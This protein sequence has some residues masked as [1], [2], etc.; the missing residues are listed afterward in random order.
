MVLSNS[1]SSSSSSTSHSNSSSRPG[2]PASKVIAVKESSKKEPKPS[3]YKPVS[4]PAPSASSK[5]PK[6]PTLKPKVVK[7]KTDVVKSEGMEK[8][9]DADTEQLFVE[10]GSGGGNDEAQVYERTDGLWVMETETGRDRG[11]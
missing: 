3:T 4:E 1:H 7:K 11:I 6:T 8:G 5:T 10:K 2:V 9:Y